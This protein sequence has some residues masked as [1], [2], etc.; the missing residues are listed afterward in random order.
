MNN[1][2]LKLLAALM[3]AMMLAALTGCAANSNND[4]VTP[5]NTDQTALTTDDANTTE[6]VTA[7]ED[8]A[9]PTLEGSWEYLFDLNEI[10][11]A[12]EDTRELAEYISEENAKLAVTLTFNA[13]G[14]YS[15]NF[16]AATL[17]NVLK[18]AFTGY[19]QAML[20]DEG[21]DVTLDEALE[22][23]G[24]SLDEMINTLLDGMEDAFEDYNSTGTWRA[25]DGK[26]YLKADG[27]TTEEYEEY[28]LTATQLTLT[29]SEND[30]EDV[31]DMFQYPIVFNRVG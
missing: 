3:A 6:D 21:S 5:E 26:L 30:Q 24:T 9:E 4:A 22:A 10:F 20:D 8:N 27:E 2:K 18:D 25:E 31:D 23:L 1:L 29:G 16:D 12:D 19:M 28:E 15:M 14:T 11:E 13:D 17:K 7:P